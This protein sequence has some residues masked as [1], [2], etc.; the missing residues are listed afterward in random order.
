MKPEPLDMSEN[1]LGRG[2]PGREILAP[3]LTYYQCA[4]HKELPTLDQLVDWA[5]R[6]C[7]TVFVCGCIV[8]RSVAH[9]YTSS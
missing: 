8:A 3:V 2:V 1:F 5:R 7:L 9:V 6:S 4:G